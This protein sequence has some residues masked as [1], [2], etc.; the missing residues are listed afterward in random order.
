[1]RKLNQTEELQLEAVLGSIILHGLT[2]EDHYLV[3]RVSYV[4]EKLFGT[5]AKGPLKDW[6]VL[7][8]EMEAPKPKKN[9][10]EEAR[11]KHPN[12]GKKWTEET[13]QEL[14]TYATSGN[15]FDRICETM[16]RSPLS[17]VM[18][19]KHLGVLDCIEDVP[20][21]FKEASQ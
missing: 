12:A 1:M 20:D 3:N 14:I 9:Q 13:D 5:K 8:G 17:I 19:A 21:H 4:T 2:T 18:R 6:L 7:C 15:E 11:K 16:G 10:W